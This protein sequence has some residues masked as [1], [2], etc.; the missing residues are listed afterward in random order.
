MP[1]PPRPQIANGFYH[2]TSRGVRKTW[3]FI[4]DDDRN[5][6]LRL[7]AVVIARYGW[8]CLAYC[9]MGNHFHLVVR[10]IDPSI[11]RGM[12]WLNSRYCEYFN[13]RYGL[14]GHV[15]E[16][17]FRSV[18]TSGTSSG[19]PYV[20]GCAGDRT[21]GGGAVTG[22]PPALRRCRGAWRRRWCGSGS[23]STPTAAR[24]CLRPSW[25]TRPNG[26]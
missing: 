5:E 25:P 14:E 24:S 12:Q 11:S 21:T 23:T 16:R 4:D 1:R 22:R 2:V 19:T 3:I 13:K 15:L 9:L 8:E 10:T 6:I 7:I 26:T 20:P 18:V 17:R